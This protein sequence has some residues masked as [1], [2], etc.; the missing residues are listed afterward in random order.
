MASDNSRQLSDATNFDEVFE[1]VKAATET[2]LG[3]HR[4]GLT[5][6]LG[7][8][9]NEIGA[10]HEMGS[11]AIV[12]NRNLLKIVSMISKSKD[13]TNSY[14][15]MILLHEYLHSLG[16]SDDEEVRL[17]SKRIADEYL[18]R[19]HPAGD[20]ATVPLDRYFPDLSK[21]MTF[22]DKGQFETVSRFDTSSTSYI[23]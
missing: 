20:M 10:Y 21:Y 2:A 22:R 14:V 17:L 18:G 15:F 5:L 3:Q 12:M 13:R 6:V 8:I 23:A 16:Y 9:P 11:N 1:M 19:E 7:D 4:A